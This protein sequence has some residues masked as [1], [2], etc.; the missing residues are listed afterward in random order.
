VKVFCG[1]GK[2]LVI[3]GNKFGEGG[4]KLIGGLQKTTRG[5]FEGKEKSRY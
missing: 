1:K 2:V 5:E 3:L 4:K